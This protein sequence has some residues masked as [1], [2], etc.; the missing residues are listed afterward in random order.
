MAGA[1]RPGGML[2]LHQPN[3]TYRC[4][5]GTRH[6]VPPEKAGQITPGNLRHG[7]T[8]EEMTNLV[9]SAGLRIVSQQALHGRFSDL[10]HQVYRMLEH[11]GFLRLASVPFTD[12]LWYLDWKFPPTHGNTVLCF[13]VKES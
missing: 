7:Y 2:V 9:T 6:F 3:T 5:D 13:A 1:L 8:P 12:V 10:A 11:P 4:F